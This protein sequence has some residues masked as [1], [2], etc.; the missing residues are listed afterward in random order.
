MTTPKAHLYF[1]RQTQ[2][3]FSS[4]ELSRTQACSDNQRLNVFLFKIHTHSLTL[5]IKKIKIKSTHTTY[6]Q[7]P[8]QVLFSLVFNCLVRPAWVPRGCILHFF[9][10][11]F[12]SLS[13]HL[14]ATWVNVQ[15]KDSPRE[16]ENSCC[17]T[18]WREIE[19]KTHF[20]SPHPILS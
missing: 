10:S 14:A 3:S 20:P 6:S 4:T 12:L 9:A 2:A 16:E 15:M 17:A 5:V 13:F 11:P 19:I 8:S 1:L 18:S 7:H